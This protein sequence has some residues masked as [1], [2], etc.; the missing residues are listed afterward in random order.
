VLTSSPFRTRTRRSCWSSVR[1]NNAAASPARS[2]WHNSRR[3]QYPRTLWRASC[4]RFP[5]GSIARPDTPIPDHRQRMIASGVYK[6]VVSQ[7][8]KSSGEVRSS[9]QRRG[10]RKELLVDGRIK[11]DFRDRVKRGRRWNARIPANEKRKRAGCA[12]AQDAAARPRRGLASRSG[13][14]H[15]S[16]KLRTALLICLI[17][18]SDLLNARQL[19]D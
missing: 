10:I 4:W 8:G 5:E 15:T 2:H 1:S 14:A 19:N 17:G 16:A 6:L 9:L 11:G 7:F 3:L 18:N 13:L 12:G